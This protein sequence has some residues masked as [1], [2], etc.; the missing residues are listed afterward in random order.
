MKGSILIGPLSHRNIISRTTDRNERTFFKYLAH[1]SAE[2][3]HFMIELRYRNISCLDI[4]K[5]TWSEIGKQTKLKRSTIIA[6]DCLQFK[7]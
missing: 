4:E 5:V 3:L 6:S 2:A 7:D 1:F